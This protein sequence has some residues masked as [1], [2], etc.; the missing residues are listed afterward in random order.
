MS[1]LEVAILLFILLELSNV[2]IIYFKPNFKYGNGL[3]V[4]KQWSQGEMDQSTHLF[5]R[6]MANW[7]ANSK[8]I[9]I[10]LLV[11][12]L[13]F[14]DDKIKLAAAIAMILSIALYY[15]TLHPLMVKMDAADLLQPKGYAKT[16]FLMITAFIVMFGVAVVFSL[17]LN[18]N[19]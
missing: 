9:F 2:L 4:F 19:L 14:G 6:Y 10:A 16:L 15:L 3:S 7:V 12:I 13:S 11:V 8:M 1:M 5:Q 17:L 18:T